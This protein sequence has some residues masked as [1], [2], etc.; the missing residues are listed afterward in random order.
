MIVKLPFGS[1]E[2]P[3]DLRGLRVRPLAPG[4]PPAVSDAGRMVADAVD[5]PVTGE[6]LSSL[7]SGRAWA[8]VVVPDATRKARLPEVLPAVVERLTS[9]GIEPSA[10]HVLVACGT[11]PPLDEEGVEGL[12]G[13]RLEG[14][15]V[16]QHDCRAEDDLVR[17][18][19][20]SWGT[21]VR[22][23]R[24]AAEA[25]LLVTVG[26][27]RH[28]YFAGFGGGPK[29][30]F[31]G[32]AGHDEIQ[33]NHA[34]VLT[35]RNGGPPERHPACEPG[36]LEGNPVAEEIAEA[37]DLRPPDMAVCLVPGRSGD[38]AWAI[39]GPWREAF[40]AAVQRAREWYEVPPAR[41]PLV[42]GSG[43]GSPSD[44]SLIQFHKALDAAC[45]FA[46]EGAEVLLVG[47]L[48]DGAGSAA[49]QPF[50]DDPA[51]ASIIRRLAARWVQ[52]G[53]TTLRIIEKTSGF[54]VFLYSRLPD[55][56]ARR[57]GFEPISDPDGVIERWRR[58]SG[59]A[60]VGVLAGQP[61][62]P[63]D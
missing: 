52:Y 55:E 11:H 6:G 31:P 38:P 34:R 51:P 45:R 59:N 23:H 18:G 49:M 32:V 13:P 37:A 17:V 3:L 56:L 29:M 4:A 57:L 53:H 61:V 36:R 25:P 46:E 63:A 41:F 19:V 7:A 5:H 54:R 60:T 28:H 9:G 43:G 24:L 2:L 58:R 50:L 20:T 15:R 30:V 40:A 27:V 33:R 62:Y 42:V 14:V 47:S 44:R 16:T 1:E 12:L 10:V 48:Q 8:T 22:L 39:A 35:M 26:A 21:P